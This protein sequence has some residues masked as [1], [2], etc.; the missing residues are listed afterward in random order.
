MVGHNRH[1]QLNTDPDGPEF[2]SQREILERLLGPS[3]KRRRKQKRDC[4][5][6]LILHTRLYTT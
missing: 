4:G 6:K 2:N 1:R 3:D 5:D